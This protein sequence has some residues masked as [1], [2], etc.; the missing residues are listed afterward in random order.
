MLHVSEIVL[1]IASGIIGTLSGILGSYV[2]IKRSM[3]PERIYGLLEDVTDMVREDTAMQQKIYGI[4]GLAGQGFIAGSG[5]KGIMPSKGGK[6][7]MEDLIGM[8]AQAIFGKVFNR[9][10]QPQQE[11][12]SDGQI[13]L[14]R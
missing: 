10:E 13:G 8:G 2:V 6:F 3:R 5:L 9:G 7:R 4:A 11:Q 14:K 12:L 1:P